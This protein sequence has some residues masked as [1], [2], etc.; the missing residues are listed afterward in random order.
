MQWTA[1][2]GAGFTTADASPWLP[3]GDFRSCNVAAQRDDPASVLA[4]CRE[5]I[6]LRRSSP[7][8]RRGP[9]ESITGSGDPWAWRRGDRFLVALNLSD[10]P[11]RVGDASGT[12]AMSTLPTRSGQRL[13]GRVELAPWEGVIV[14]RASTE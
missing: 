4:F 12:V 9:Y 11:V 10:E 1:E 14:D 7:E 13:R 5:L 6:A 3:L 8:L 2:P